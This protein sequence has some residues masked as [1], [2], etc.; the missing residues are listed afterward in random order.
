MKKIQLLSALVFSVFVSACT[1]NQE[2][3]IYTLYSTNH[4]SDS[5]RSGI[6]TFD[7]VSS[8]QAGVICQEAAD[9]YAEDFKKRKKINNWDE[10]TKTRYWCEKGR[11]KK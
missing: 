1:K 6:A 9:M 2:E 7:L 5:G 3:H 10:S 8:E 11:F 4:P